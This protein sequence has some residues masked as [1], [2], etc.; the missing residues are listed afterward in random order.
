[1]KRTQ[2]R[3]TLKT[4]VEF[5]TVTGDYTA[6]NQAL[7]FIDGFLSERGM[8]VTRFESNG[9][10]SLVAT[11]RRTKT[12]KVML[13]AHLDV[14]PAPENFFSVRQ[15]DDRLY[16]RGVL[17]MKFA[18]AA[19]L[20]LVDDLKDSLKDYD[21]GV[22]ITT[23]EES[24]GKEGVSMLLE[25]GYVPQVCILPDGG[26][27]WQLQLASKGFLYLRLTQFGKQSHGSRPWLGENAILGLM[28]SITEIQ[29]LF[30]ESNPDSN[31]LNVGAFSGGQAPNQVADFAEALLD[32]RLRSESERRPIME[33][34]EAICKRNKT[35]YYIEINGP[36]TDFRLDNPFIA[37]FVRLIT[38]HTGVEVKGSRTLGSSDARHYA[39][40]NVP[41][42][43]F[44]PTGGGHHGIDEWISVEALGQ[45]HRILRDYV[46]EIARLD[47]SV[48]KEKLLLTTTH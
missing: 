3:K 7:E 43:S 39:P 32:I 4:L 45:T 33:Q 40:F 29:L 23:D 36:A 34:L 21:F 35:E 26:D 14:I 5:P 12:P 48:A 11:T 42:I 22:M 38:Q 47:Q 41:C 8:L 17:D 25:K 19:Y 1:M 20:Q 27:D 30:P 16:G 10:E 15:V 31:T 44:Y 18:I 24:G 6:N 2:L 37:P 9:F 28:Q 13:G 46:E